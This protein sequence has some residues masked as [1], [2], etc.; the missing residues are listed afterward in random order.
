MHKPTTPLYPSTD[1]RKLE[2]LAPGGSLMAKAGQALATLA[3]ELAAET[4]D[5]ILIVAGPGN[6]GG[7]AL[8]AARLLKQK[9]HQVV[10][11]LAGDPAKMPE[12][13]AHAYQAWLADGGTCLDEIPPSPQFSLAIDGLFG[14]GLQRPLEGRYAALVHAIN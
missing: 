12:D 14:I 1:I 6:N 5:P 8:V 10:V 9:W 11:V 7:D 2:Q 3:G 4:S 13:A